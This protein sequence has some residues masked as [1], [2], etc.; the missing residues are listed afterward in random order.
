MAFHENDK[1]IVL[2]EPMKN[3]LGEFLRGPDGSLQYLRLAS[4]VLRKID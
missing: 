2:D 4:R 1:L 3:A